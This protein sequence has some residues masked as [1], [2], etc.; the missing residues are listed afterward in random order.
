M[1]IPY[2]WSRI[3]M[4]NHIFPPM[5]RNPRSSDFPNFAKPTN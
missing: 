4:E 2:L 3:R 1:Q 5:R